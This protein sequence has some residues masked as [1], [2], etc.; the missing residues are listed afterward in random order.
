MV[1]FSLFI[2]LFS[3]L[4]ASSLQVEVRAGSA[5]V[6]NPE[7]KA[8]LYEKNA[9][10]L[11][12]PASTTKVAT[13][14]YALKE[15]GDD[16]QVL[17]EADQDCIGSITPQMQSSMNYRYPPH[18]LVLGGTH[19]SIQKKDKL[20]LEDLLYGMLLAS[21]NDAANMIAKYIGGSIPEFMQELNEYL[22]EIGCT[23]TRFKNPHGMAYPGHLTTAHDLAI[24]ASEAFRHP[25]FRKIVSSYKYSRPEVS[26]GKGSIYN[27]NRL[28]DKN[29]PYYYP[30]AVGIKT[31]FYSDQESTLI[32]AA[33]Y[34]G[35]TL[36]AVLLDAESDQ[37]YEDAI[38]LFEAAFREQKVREVYLPKGKQRF[39]KQSEGSKKKIETYLKKDLVL[40]FYEAER[41]YVHGRIHWHKSSLPVQKNEEVARISL[42]DSRD[43]LLAEEPLYA[44]RNIS[45]K[46]KGKKVA[47]WLFLPL[48][49]VILFLMKESKL[50]D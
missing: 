9:H 50:N 49:F 48:I 31:G 26:D 23:N 12:R 1:L 35:R 45:E 20:P 7:T 18:W 6:I 3:F 19:M 46:K 13:A 21:A 37:R 5:I 47:G 30:Y 8:V 10:E 36:I 34:E 16:L 2:S 41:P 4:G 39:K 27:L 15:V 42:Y 40:S 44:C 43:R 28:L 33:T 17:I 11:L 22:E 32:A 24:M 29:G 25:I 38:R 14:L